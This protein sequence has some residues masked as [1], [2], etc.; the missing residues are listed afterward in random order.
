[1]TPYSSAPI[2]TFGGVRQHLSPPPLPRYTVLGETLH[3]VLRT[4]EL[5]PDLISHAHYDTPDLWWVICVHNGIR[6]PFSVRAG[7]YLRIPLIEFLPSPR[8]TWLAVE[9]T[10]PLPTSIPQ[11]PPLSQTTPSSTP[12]T[13]SLNRYLYNFRVPPCLI[14]RVHFEIQISSVET[15]DRVLLGK[16]SSTSASR[17]FIDHG[18]GYEAWTGGVDGETARLRS[19]YFAILDGD[20][21]VGGV[22]YWV[23]IRPI[24]ENNTTVY[25]GAW[26]SNA[27][28][29]Q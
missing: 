24:V 28:V 3:T 18:S 26:E 8:E 27:T 1:M 20:P 2:I 9:N 5:R 14:G 15:F 21:I 12:K 17:W 19:C 22:Q 23:R 11:I 13:I 29:F 7:D 16:M 4:E 10:F 6:D 25:F